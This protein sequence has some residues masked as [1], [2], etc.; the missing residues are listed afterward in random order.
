MDR[1]TR[2]ALLAATGAALAGLSGCAGGLGAGPDDADDGGD[3]TTTRTPASSTQVGAACT[4]DGSDWSFDPGLVWVEAGGSVTW[5]SQTNCA[6]R[7]FA[8]H[9]ENDAPRRIPADATPFASDYLK[10]S[11]STYDHT[12]ETPGVYDYFGLN[13]GQVGTVVVGRPSPEGQPGLATPQSDLPEATREEL[14]RLNAETRSL[15]SNI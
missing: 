8:Y 11:G 15:L 9:P 12:F 10:Q 6:Q 14:S 5:V 7:I 13:A 1:P 2:R 3:T 4:T